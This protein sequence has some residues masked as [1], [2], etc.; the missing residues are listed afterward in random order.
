MRLTYQKFQRSLGL[1]VLMMTAWLTMPSVAYADDFIYDGLYYSTT[2]EYTAKVVAPH[3]GKYVGD[4][5]I[6]ETVIYNGAKYRVTAIGDNAFKG[7]HSLTSVTLPLATIESIGEYAFNDC[8]GLTEFTLPASITSIGQNAFY[9]CD[10]LKDLYVHSTNPASYKPGSMAFSKIHYGSHVCTLHVPTGCTA[11]YAADATFSVF[12]Q[13]EEFDPPHVYSL[14]VAG[15]KVTSVN[16][17]DILGDGV[18]SYDAFTKTL[19]IG[20]NITADGS[21]VFGDGISSMIIGLTIQVSAPTTI[22]ARNYGI[23]ALASTTITGSSLLTITSSNDV[24]ISFMGVLTIKDANLSLTGYMKGSGWLSD[25]TIQ[26]STIDVSTTS[27]KGAIYDWYS[28]TLTDCYIATPEDGV[29]DAT[30]KRVEDK[31]GNPAKHVVIKAGKP[32]PKPNG[33]ALSDTEAS[34]KMDETFTPPNLTN[35]NN[36][37]VTWSSSDET[38]ATVNA[39]TGEVYLLKPGSTTI[40][41]SF[42]GN[43]DYQAGSVSYVLTIAKYE[44]GL[45]FSETSA[46]AKIDE[47]FYEPTLTNPNNLPVT[48]TSSDE[49]VAT[50]DSSSGI[51]TTLLKSGTT[52]ITAT[53]AGDDQY[54]AGSASYGLTV[55][56]GEAYL[57]FSETSAS[58]TFGVDFYAPSLVNSL[59][60]PVTYASSDATVATVNASTGEVTLL[61]SGSTTITATFAGNDQ[62][63]AVSA[64]YDLTVAKGDVYLGFDI[65]DNYAKYG[66]TFTTPTLENSLELPV[67]YASSDETVATVNASTGD[68][69]LLKS[70]NTTITVTFAG[71]DQYEAAS[72]SYSLTIEKGD[73]NLAFDAYD[74]STKIGESFTT[75]TLSN[76][77]KLPVTYASSDE[78]VATVNASTGEVTLVSDGA[79]TITASFVGNDQ[80]ETCDVSYTIYVSKKDAVE[81][82]LAISATSATAKMGESF[83]PPTLTNPNKLAVT[84]T[85]SD[86]SVAMVEAETGKVTLVG[87]GIT[88]IAATFEGNDD[89]MAGSVSYT[90]VVEKKDPAANGL[91]FSATEASAKIGEAFTP[92]TLTN[93]NKLTV[94]WTSSDESVATV[95]AETGE[96]ALVASGTTIITAYFDGNY[97][98]AAGSV[99]YALT[100]TDDGGDTP[101]N[102][103]DP[104]NPDNPDDPDQP[105]DPDNPDDPD[106]PDDPDQ[107]DDPDNPDN[108]DDPDNPDNPDTPDDPDDPDQPEP[109]DNGLAFTEA[110]VSVNI[111]DT[112]IKLPEL[113]NPNNLAVKWSSSDETVAIVDAETGEVTIVGPGT[114]TITATFEGDDDH[115]KSS[116]DYTLKI[117][118]ETAIFGVYT[119]DAQATWHDLNGIRIDKPTRKGLYIRNGKKVVIK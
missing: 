51:V 30:D 61:K 119:D 106:T 53:F 56:K 49:T 3:D 29:Y 39:S 99:N 35:P 13:V 103:D 101:D 12:T 33:L 23:D 87:D 89:F 104:D 16:A 78:T 38:V 7:A 36:L 74:V 88:T 57:A 110:E 82:G 8:T 97:D 34:A 11:A 95:N 70:G 42:A 22:T 90:L 66:E 102:P 2:S 117:E 92:P 83:T 9:Y 15:T 17:S 100:V 116:V 60:L 40:T 105:D 26:S 64:S 44:A 41:A 79:A 50:V 55:A 93:P 68:V 96:V 52:T 24:A 80:Y 109:D 58:A 65:Y 112:E 85:S 1:V 118:G 115:P 46:S 48:F 81:N 86:E 27:A 59:E 25:M 4:I 76:P 37:D 67:T 63:E 84:W 113:K 47:A 71:N 5:T 69:K 32:D 45:A 108:P 28:V 62:Y 98:F 14:W 72:T 111:D 73:A 19:T 91:A 107:P 10:N 77:L 31:D 6:P 21:S 114:A 94:T 75:P 43:D 20:G 18:A 54:E